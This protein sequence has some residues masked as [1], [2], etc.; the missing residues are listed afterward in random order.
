MPPKKRPKPKPAAQSKKRSGGGKY[1]LAGLVIV[2]VVA[3]VVIGLRYFRSVSSETD[4]N[5][6]ARGPASA[7]AVMH[8]YS[9]FT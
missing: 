9:S 5:L 7:P 4:V 8:E 2:I 6:F 3:A 1:A